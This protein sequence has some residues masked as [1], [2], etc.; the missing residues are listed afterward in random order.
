MHDKALKFSKMY[1][2]KLCSLKGKTRLPYCANFELSNDLGL[3]YSFA[4]IISVVK[5]GSKL[6]LAENV[7]FKTNGVCAT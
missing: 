4:S 2:T 3:A 7:N 6:F 5:L 1:K